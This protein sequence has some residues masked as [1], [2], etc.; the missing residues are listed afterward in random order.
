MGVI[1]S[2]VT[3]K[4]DQTHYT[5]QSQSQLQGG[6]H[7]VARPAERWECRKKRSFFLFLIFET[8]L[9][10]ALITVLICIKL[11]RDHLS[12]NIS[13]FLKIENDILVDIYL[14]NK[15]EYILIR[16]PHKNCDKFMTFIKQLLSHSEPKMST[17]WL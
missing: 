11:P 9:L 8:F 1:L 12:I 2:T 6:K 15:H 16:L 17:C 10:L 13:D 5:A 7:H 14:L 3:C 4:H